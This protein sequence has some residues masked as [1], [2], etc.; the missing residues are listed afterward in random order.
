[1]NKFSLI[2]IGDKAE[3]THKITKSDVEKFIGLTGDNNKLHT[4]KE[5]AS[6]TTFKKPIVHGMLGASFISTVIGTKLPGNGALWFAQNIEFLLP[7]RIGDEITVKAEVIG[8]YENIQVLK[9]S[10]DIFNQYNQ[11]VTKGIAK[12][13]ILEQTQFKKKY[14]DIL[15]INTDLKDNH[16][17]ALYN[18]LVLSNITINQIKEILEYTLRKEG[19]NANVKIGDYDNIVQDSTKNS[20]AVIIFWEL[21]NIVDGLQHKIELYNDKQFNEILEKTKLEIDLVLE[22][23]SKTSLVLFNK[24][25]AMPFSG[26]RG[27]NLERL[28]RA[29]NKHIENRTN[30]IDLDKINRDLDFRYY[31]SS[32]ALYN[33][34]FFKDYSEYIKPYIMSVNGKAKKAL[35]FDCDNTLWKGIL[36]EDGFDKIE[37]SQKTKDGAIF[38]EVQDI[39]LSLNRQGILI[40]LCSGNNPEDVEEVINSHIDMKLRRE[41]ITVNKSNWL[42]KVTN[43]RQIANELNIGLD[44]IV[45]IDDSPF[46][47][48]LIREGLPEITVL[49]VPKKLYEYPMFLRKNLDL[50]YNLNSTKED[51]DKIEMYKQEIYRKNAKKG[52]GN[53]EEY[54]ASLGL[55][56]TIFEGDKSII[57]RMSQMSQKTNQF[58]LTTKRYTE[59]DIRNFIISDNS[60]VFCF[61]I[62]DKFGDSG[63]TGLCIVNLKSKTADI[64]TFL[65]SCRIIGRNVEF[66]FMDYLIDFLKNNKIKS[67]TA[68]YI[69]TSKN[70]QVEDFYDKC[71]F[72]LT[73]SNNGIKNY[74]LL[75]RGYKSKKIRYIEVVSGR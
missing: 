58:N 19:I 29:L 40:G 25:T 6:K 28:A 47:V 9:L 75:I 50:F 38:S 44:S 60:K 24:F 65:I 39:A 69:K 30:I 31:Y 11:R 70:K 34:E 57:P 3:I 43:L 15:K 27:S 55:K 17:V 2:N 1:M 26:I 71:S 73:K 52:F 42:D 8:K 59:I 46:E 35:I 53:I 68:K 5:Y 33:I 63:I 67:V 23:L 45:F 37:M 41:H 54:L 48:N 62:S 18:I 32:K 56:L 72:P 10:T 64:D 14:A 21:C 61:S 12:V 16:L 51:K 36:G 4:D 74:E 49:Q 66:A 13:K 22:N 7:V 20:N